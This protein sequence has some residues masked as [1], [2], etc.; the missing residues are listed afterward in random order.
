V[1]GL[2]ASSLET[3]DPAGSLWNIVAELT[4]EQGDSAPAIRVVAHGTPR[5][6]KPVVGDEVYRIAGEALRNALRH[7]SA[8]HVAAEIR[9]DDRRFRV[10]VRDD[11]KGFDEQAVRRD[12]PAGHF[13]LPGMLERAETLGGSLEVWSKAGFGT[14][15]ELS[16]P[17]AVAYAPSSRRRLLAGL[18]GSR[19]ARPSGLP[20]RL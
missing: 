18:F 10:R 9:Y 19:S 5:R 13:G 12:P 7:A 6:L 17:A 14:A 1:Q 3:T 15:I 16:I 11:G 2:R 20:R 8:Q 4:R